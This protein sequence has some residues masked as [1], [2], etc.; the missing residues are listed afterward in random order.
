MTA[1]AAQATRFPGLRSPGR[2]PARPRRRVDTVAQPHDIT[3]DPDGR[4]TIYRKRVAEAAT[5]RGLDPEPWAA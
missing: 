1:Q 3:P 5:R 2:S 4:V